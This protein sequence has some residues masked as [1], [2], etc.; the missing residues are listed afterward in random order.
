MKKLV[1]IAILFFSVFTLHAQNKFTIEVYR[2]KNQTFSLPKVKSDFGFVVLFYERIVYNFDFQNS[3]E[4]QKLQEACKFILAS[5]KQGKKAQLLVKNYNGSNDLY[6]NFGQFQKDETSILVTSNYDTVTK[7]L[8][9]KGDNFGNTFA[10]LYQVVDGNV[11]KSN[12]PQEAEKS[13]NKLKY[14][15]DL[16]FDKNKKNDAQI[17]KLLEK[18]IEEN[19]TPGAYI[20]LSQFY[21]SNKNVN[22]G[23]KFLEESKTHIV[24][25]KNLSKIY[26]CTYAQGKAL[27][28]ISGR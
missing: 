17:K 15:N 24:K 2:D 10:L 3:V 7:K 12:A 26:D 27:E 1:L 11:V 25:D 22:W 5:L 21:F 13:E 14:A 6:F 18:E 28:F 4:S 16:L 8:L 20:V 23:L 9:Q 19:K